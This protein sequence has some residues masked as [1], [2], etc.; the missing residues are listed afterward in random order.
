MSKP[1]PLGAL[2]T[3][4][5]RRGGWLRPPPAPA[6]RGPAGS[7][8]FARS[9]LAPPR[10]AGLESTFPLRRRASQ[11]DPKPFGLV[12]RDLFPPPLPCPLLCWEFRGG[13]GG[14][15]GPPPPGAGVGAGRP[16]AAVPRPGGRAAAPGWHRSAPPASSEQRERGRAFPGHCQPA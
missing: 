5:P 11:P 13:N 1:N 9:P 6:R 16:A 2:P 15:S 4:L 8:R 12:N 3:P 14:C 10:G 7:L